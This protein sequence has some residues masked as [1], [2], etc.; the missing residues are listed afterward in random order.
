ME[1]TWKMREITLKF[2]PSQPMCWDA[3]QQSDHLRWLRLIHERR[4]LLFRQAGHGTQLQ[5]QLR[6]LTFGRQ[7]LL[8]GAE[9][10]EKM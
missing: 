4:H 3:L 6:S 10:G 5:Q 7:V 9:N 2:P 8:T 1:K